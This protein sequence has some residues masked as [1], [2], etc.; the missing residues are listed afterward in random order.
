[1]P[2]VQVERVPVEIFGLGMLGFDHLQIIFRSDLGGA[3]QRQDGWFVLEGLR[4]PH[5]P[6][7]RL[8]VEGWH[9]G[10]TLSEANGG[11]TG[12]ALAHRIGTAETRGAREIASGEGATALWADLVSF[13]ADIERQQ[14]P[15]IALA[16]ASSP[17]PTV[18]SS[19]LVASLLH[20]AGIPM[21]RA[22]PFGLRFSPGTATL[23]GTSHD[24]RMQTG[25]EFST[26]VGGEGRDDL[27]GSP[28]PGRIDKL[29]GGRGDDLFH[30]SPGFNIVHGGQP[31]LAYADDG[32][33]TI[34]YS[35]AG[36]LRID[37]PGGATPHLKA[38]FVVTTESGVDHLYSIEEIAWDDASDRLVIGKGVGLADASLSID[39]GGEAAH[40][41]GDVLDLSQADTGFTLR[42]TASGTL[43]V[44]SNESEAP[45]GPLDVAGAEWVVG[46]SFGDRMVLPPG[47]RGAEGG[48]GDDRFDLIAA[49]ALVVTGG[50]GADTF[51]IGRGPQ[52]VTGGPGADRYLIANPDARLVI[53]D[54]SPEDRIVL[55]EP[56]ARLVLSFDPAVPGDVIIRIGSV[57]DGVHEAEIRVR[58][59]V[60]GDLGLDPRAALALAPDD[61]GAGLLLTSDLVTP[62]LGATVVEALDGSSDFGGTDLLGAG[63]LFCLVPHG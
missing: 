9:G 14:F 62:D 43:R 27:S 17:L 37:A 3:V 55:A 50:A 59:F 1:M 15:Y 48:A 35:G 38:D 31:G 20:H 56:P 13:A 24:D 41:P 34:D 18:N 7:L 19:S 49:G 60:P 54:A 33:D 21:A 6:G 51:A 12:E 40:G 28:E 39:L 29:Y 61:G 42:P 30:W 53:A 8:A 23:L 45:H 2:T 22:L 58:G 57:S 32:R 25:G 44:S 63:P 52:I 47:L 10:T 5:G 46:S 11:L 36:V 26:L 16:L 4:E